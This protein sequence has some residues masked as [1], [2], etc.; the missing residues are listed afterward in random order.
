MAWAVP[1]VVISAAAA[2]VAAATW[3]L[4]TCS[5]FERPDRSVAVDEHRVGARRRC[6]DDEESARGAGCHVVRPRDGPLGEGTDAFCAC[7]LAQ[8]PRRGG[9]TRGWPAVPHWGHRG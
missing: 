7:S 8:T 1:A 5:S 4:F 9:T 3:L 2:M 6:R